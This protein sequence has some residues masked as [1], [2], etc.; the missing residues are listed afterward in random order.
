MTYFLQKA[1]VLP[2]NCLN[3][4]KYNVCCPETKVVHLHKIFVWI[5]CLFLINNMLS[6]T[7]AMS[8]QLQLSCYIELFIYDNMR[9]S[10]GFTDYRITALKFYDKRVFV[11]VLF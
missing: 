9:V 10:M 5:I 4:L 8:A 3:T 2:D 7:Y 1:K 11:L 6:I